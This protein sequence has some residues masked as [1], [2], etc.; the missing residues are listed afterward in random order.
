MPLLP[1]PCSYH[2]LS[3]LEN[4]GEIGRRGF[5]FQDHVAAGYCIQMLYDTDLLQ[6]W[7]ENHD[8]ITLNRQLTQGESFEFVQ[9][10]GN[11]LG[12][13]WSVEKLCKR[14]KKNSKFVPGTSILER[15][16]AYDRGKEHCSFRIITRIPV[17]DLLKV[18]LLPLTAPD[19]TE[20]C[21]RLTALCTQVK[22]KL[23]DYLSPN[24][25]DVADWIHKTQWEVKQS[26]RDIVNENILKLMDFATTMGVFLV[27]D[28]AREVYAKIHARVQKAALSQWRIDPEAK[29]IGR[30]EFLGWVKQLMAQAQHPSIGGKGEK[31]RE[32]MEAAVIPLDR[33]ETAQELRRFYRRRSLN[34]GYLDLSRMKDAELATQARLHQ[35]LCQL[36]A[37]KLADSGIEFHSRC[38]EL[39]TELGES[40]EMP[41]HSLQGYMY[42]LTDRCL[43]RFTRVIL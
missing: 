29:K 7:C 3:P 41:L 38:L 18:L 37:E 13:F 1:S 35:L 14:D 19:R 8:D 40:E 31:L 28:Q 23:P 16:L 20:P 32:K 12:Q 36:D 39:L 43:H 21:D 6:V 25:Q 26:E 33:I 9:V 4:G 11:E 42:Y 10:K 17:N 30:D 24:G 27:Q 15:S 2:D 5:D 22:K 34:P